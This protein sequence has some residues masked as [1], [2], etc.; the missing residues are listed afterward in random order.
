M[1]ARISRVS[2]SHLAQLYYGISAMLIESAALYSLPAIVFVIGYSLQSPLQFAVEPVEMLQGVAPLMIILR[3]ARGTAITSN[4]STGGLHASNA[5][6]ST[7]QYAENARSAS[8][9]RVTADPTRSSFV[10]STPA[11]AKVRSVQWFTASQGG[12][13]SSVELAVVGSVEDVVKLQ[14]DHTGV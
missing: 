7:I 4:G 10:E 8:E 14:V 3:V 6:V 11:S 13:Q 12:D 2:G 5:G 9:S 1:R